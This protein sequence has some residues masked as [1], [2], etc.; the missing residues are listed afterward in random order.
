MC[1]RYIWLAIGCG[2]A[3]LQI[4]EAAQYARPYEPPTHPALLPLPPGAVE[5]KGWLRDWC[6]AAKNGYTGHMDD[7]DVA[8]QHAWAADYKMTGNNLTWPNGAWPYEGGGYWFDGLVRLGYALHDDALIQQATNRMNVVVNNMTANSILSLWWLDRNNAADRSSIEIDDAWPMWACGLL[9]RS[10]SG[11]Y[12]ASGNAG[13]LQTLQ[14]SFDTSPDLLRLAWGMS[15]TWPAYD[16]YTWTG[17]PTI[18]NNLATVFANGGLNTGTYSWNRYKRLPDLAPGAEAN[19]HVVHFLEST[20]PWLLGYLWTGDA[21]YLNAVLGWHSL[22]EQHS[23][24]P[25]GV[26]V[27][28]ESYGP[29][30]AFRGTETCDVAAYIWSQ[31]MLLG[32]TGNGQ[33]ADRV[34][35]AF[36]NAGPATVSRDFTKHVY[37]QCPNRATGTT[38]GSRLSGHGSGE[39]FQSVHAPL[40][41]TAALNRIVPWYV[42]H[43]WMATYDNGLAATCY[44]PCKVTA[45]VAD[46]VPVV[47]TSTTDYPFNE[48]IE[49]SVAPALEREFPLSFHIPGWCA[50]PALSVNGSAI[51]VA[52]DANGFMRVNRTWKAGDTVSLSFPMT[53]RVETGRD[54]NARHA[55]FAAVSYGPLLFARAIPDT[56]DANTPD[57]GATWK[58][59]LNVANPGLTVVRQAMPST[60]NWPLASPIQVKANAVAVDW[61][62]SFDSPQ[63]PAKA[64]AQQEPVEQITLIPYG[65]TKLRVSMFPVTAT[66]APVSAV[67]PVVSNVSIS[68]RANSRTVDIAYTLSDAP[69]IIT[70]SIETNGV[71]LPDSEVVSLSGDVCKRVEP[72]ARS[73]VW[74]AGKDWPDKQVATVKALVTA[75]PTNDPPLYMVVDLSQGAGASSYPARYYASEEGLPEGGLSNPLYKTS[76]LVMRRVRTHEAAPENGVF[77]M[78]S[79]GGETGRE[80]AGFLFSETQHTVTLTQDYYA[81]IFEVTQGQWLKVM[82][83]AAGAFTN[84]ATRLMRP[85]EHVAYNTLRGSGWPVADP[86]DGTFLRRLQTKTGFFGFDLPTEAQWEYACRAGTTSP[87]Y[88]GAS[89]TIV[90]GAAD[91]NLDHLGRYKYNGGD[92]NI[93]GVWYEPGS[94]GTSLE[95]PASEG[96]AVVGSYLPNPWGL[97]DTLGNVLEVC[98]DWGVSDLGSAPNTD[99][100]GAASGSSRVMK[101]AAYGDEPFSMRAGMRR[102]WDPNS[103]HQ[104]IGFRVV[105]NLTE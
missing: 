91:P 105:M 45:W 34:E 74:K 29:T 36:F 8:F 72:G 33:R 35:R 86:S 79:P 16:T 47:I 49:L 100:E 101:G 75:W 103:F 80:A 51:P 54:Y 10:L 2:M 84:E 71:A 62:P 69:G 57:A 95:C 76:R 50:A 43:M 87:L 18:S 83:S 89:L 65:C 42:T 31:I 17:N 44:G 85:L 56:T 52:A 96:T 7:F 97:Y 104:A 14:S 41:C 64:F 19:D 68:Q 61:S 90:S 98:L 53:A 32:V 77:S 70:L 88:S 26:P 40:C 15:T 27:A 102:G 82:G 28:D 99:P 39:T 38:S 66:A 46:H 58:Y 30:G 63:L 59:A 67:P 60:W 11:Y 94:A 81:G 37:F 22:L 92:Y 12:A 24:Q 25:S 48:S 3:F 13:V 9:G 78:G 4:S 93:G 23:M 6:L 20:T 21:S 5:P 1:N 73:M 55:P